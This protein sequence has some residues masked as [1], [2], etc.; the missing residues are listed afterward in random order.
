MYA[1][2]SKWKPKS[3]KEDEFKRLSRAAREK[4]KGTPG[5]ELMQGFRNEKGEYVVF[6]GYTDEPTYQKVIHDPNGPFARVMDETK[7]E[8]CG[9][10]LYSERGE[11]ID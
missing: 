5:I 2:M 9:E 1:V 8:E 4:L 7:L 11:A 6:M 10:W 3:G